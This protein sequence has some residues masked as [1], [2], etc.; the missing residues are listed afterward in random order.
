MIKALR[1]LWNATRG[2]RLWPMRSPYFRWRVETYSGMSA[3]TLTDWKV[4]Q[5]VWQ[6]KWE[7]LKY[8]RWVDTL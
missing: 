2:C 4:L 8:L 7:L 1:F 3:E 5:F 6:Y